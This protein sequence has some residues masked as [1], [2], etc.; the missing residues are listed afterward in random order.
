MLYNIFYAHFNSDVAVM[1]PGR[2]GISVLF[3]LWTQDKKKKEKEKL[4]GPQCVD[5]LR[6]G[7]SV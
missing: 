1:I 6:Q 3:F 2:Q 5:C 4:R 7:V